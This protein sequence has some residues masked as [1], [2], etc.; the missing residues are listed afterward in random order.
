MDYSQTRKM[1]TV[2]DIVRIKDTHQ[3]L[4]LT[5]KTFTAT[6]GMRKMKGRDMKITE[7]KNTSRCSAG[8]V[9]AGGWVWH[10]EDLYVV[11]YNNE[12]PLVNDGPIG[13]FKFDP[14]SL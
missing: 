2:G 5:H 3:N 10:P 8:R 12:S 13:V 4:G 6:D 14:K 1:F 7:V 11:S 9:R